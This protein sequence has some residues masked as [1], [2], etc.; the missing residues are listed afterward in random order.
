MNFSRLPHSW[1]FAIPLRRPRPSS[2]LGYKTH[3]AVLLLAVALT[4]SLCAFNYVTDAQGTWWGIQDAASPGVDTGSIR[5]TQIAAGQEGAF[6]TSINGFGGIRV[7]VQTSP[8]PRFNGEVMRGFGLTF[9]GV[10]HF[11]T[12]QSVDLGGVRISRSITINRGANWGRW[13]DTFTNTTDSP[14][15]IQVAFGGQSGIGASGPN[16]SQ[17]VNTSSGDAIV[18]AADSWALV[19]TPLNGDT[20]VGGPQATVIG[21][22]TTAASPFPGAMTFAGNWLFDTFNTPLSYSG[23]EGNFQA[24]INT[25]RCRPEAAG[26]FCTSSSSARA[27]TRRRRTRC[28]RRLKRPPPPWRPHPTRPA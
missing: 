18:T 20:L 19:A 25:S 7:L 12:T 17:L 15:T 13:L 5:A 2:N 22:P 23:H 27:S 14:L 3:P 1:E 16:S 6:S 11:T 28:A 26:R 8:A 21:T 10:D 24:Y 9:D 4:Q